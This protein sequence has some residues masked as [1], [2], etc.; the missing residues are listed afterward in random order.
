VDRL[1]HHEDVVDIDLLF[2]CQTYLRRIGR[3]YACG[4]GR[5]VQVRRVNRKLRE[6]A[7]VHRSIAK[8][9]CMVALYV[10]KQATDGVVCGAAFSTSNGITIVQIQSGRV[11]ERP[12]VALTV[13]AQERKLGSKPYC[14]IATR[15]F[16]WSTKRSADLIISFSRFF[17]LRANCLWSMA[18]HSALL[19]F[20]SYILS[21]SCGSI[22]SLL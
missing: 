15:A 8:D 5:R 3:N 13:E 6:Y 12:D 17:S 7:L 18:D 2:R 14:G 9:E 22:F 21:A 4:H 16:S 11:H 1:V 19:D 20:A 10:V